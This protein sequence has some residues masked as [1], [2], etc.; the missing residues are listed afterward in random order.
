MLSRQCHFFRR[1]SL[2]PGSLIAKPKK[3]PTKTT[4]AANAGTTDEANGSGGKPTAAAMVAKQTAN[5]EEEAALNDVDI[6]G[7]REKRVD[8]IFAQLMKRY[9][10]DELMQLTE[11]LA[12]HLGMTLVPTDTWAALEEAAR[13]TTTGTG[14]ERRI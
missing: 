8:W 4:T 13:P 14:F 3:K 10:Q 6:E 12:K 7:E 5:A 9:P 2:D 11:R 1:H